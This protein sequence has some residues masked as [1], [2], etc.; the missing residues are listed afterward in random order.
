MYKIYLQIGSIPTRSK[1]ILLSSPKDHDA[2]AF[3]L[4][5]ARENGSLGSKVVGI[6]ARPGVPACL[7][8][9]LCLAAVSASL[10]LSQKKFQGAG[11]VEK[12]EA[13]DAERTGA[14]TP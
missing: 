3:A 8:A 2:R 7:Y 4:S 6:P 10:F 12:R 11:H 1:C 14:Y 9:V 5:R 13:G